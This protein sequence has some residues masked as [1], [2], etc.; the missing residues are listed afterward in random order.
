MKHSNRTQHHQATRR[1]LASTRSKRR[2]E[3][4][5]LTGEQ[6]MRAYKWAEIEQERKT[7]KLRELRL[8]TGSRS[9]HA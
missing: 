9:S 5:R 7:E 8:R 2:Q 1:H 4:Q 3:D 6:A